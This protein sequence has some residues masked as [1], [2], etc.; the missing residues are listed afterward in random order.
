[1]GYKLGIGLL[2]FGILLSNLSADVDGGYFFVVGL[3]FGIVGLIQVA[4]AHSREKKA[5]FSYRTFEPYD[6]N[7]QYGQ[8]NVFVQNDINEQK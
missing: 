8:N 3:L 5:Y 7:N 6:Q 1:M 4:V 2:L